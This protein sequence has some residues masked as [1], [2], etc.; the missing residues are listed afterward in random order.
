M[1]PRLKG[2]DHVHIYVPD[3]AAAQRWYAEMLDLH[4]AEAFSQ[5]ATPSGPLT[6]ENEE[7]S[8]HLALFERE[9]TPGSTLALGASGEEFL[10]W[11]AHFASLDMSIRVSDHELAFSLYFSDPWGNQHEITSYDHELIRLARQNLA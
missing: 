4:P 9:Q 8:V 6:L 2:I 10:A 5:W 11:C 7:G 3:R 1:P